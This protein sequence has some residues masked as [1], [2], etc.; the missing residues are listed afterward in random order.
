MRAMKEEK[1]QTQKIRIYSEMLAGISGASVS[2]KKKL[3][4]ISYV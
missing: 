1:N 2:R 3:V 4:V